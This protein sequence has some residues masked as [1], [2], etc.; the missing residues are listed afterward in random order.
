MKFGILTFHNTLNPGA[1]LQAYALCRYIRQE[2]DS[3]DIIDYRSPNIVKRELSF[4]KART[5]LRTLVLRL[6]VWPRQKLKIKK[7]HE[8]LK[9]EKM[10]SP[11]S[12]SPENIAEANSDYDGF[13]AGSDQIWN[14]K[15]TD[16]DYNFFLKFAEKEKTKL[17]Y[18]TSAGD[19]WE[20]NEHKD[21]LEL[22][23]RFDELSVREESTRQSLKKCFGIES[24]LVA[25]PTMLL[26]PQEWSELAVKPK[27]KNYV[28]VYMPQ[29]G[30]NIIAEEFAR[31]ENKKLI[32]IGDGGY[33]LKKSGV[34]SVN[35]YEWLGYIKY[36]D[37]VF[38]DSYHG[39]LFSLYFGKNV[40][41]KLTEKKGE[42]QKTIL[43]I[44]D[45]NECAVS[46]IQDV[47]ICEDLQK[48]P[49]K[50]EHF[51]MQSQKYLMGVLSE[52]R[53]NNE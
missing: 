18:A 32:H 23:G 14:L 31:R 2:G 41:T 37:A 48:R 7:F 20:K 24:E 38:T 36:A 44:I 49:E 53:T 52:Y 11:K 3:C 50:L 29:G 42:R 35:V 39:L 30:V 28:L 26:S 16:N 10:L 8:F 21:V 12:Y 47:R 25:D 51:R 45:A 19:E 34:R 46:N 33:H 17:S 4:K 40:W 13:I 15:I 22:L 1:T 9:S 6:F 27:E 43:N 5:A